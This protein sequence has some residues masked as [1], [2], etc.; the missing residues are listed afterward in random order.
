MNRYEFRLPDIGEGTAEAECVAWHVAPGDRVEED[1]PLVDVMTD[2]ATVEVTSPVAGIIRE[3][4]GAAGDMMAVGSTI[5]VFDLDAEGDPAP[6]E[7]DNLQLE[8]SSCVATPAPLPASHTVRVLA[9]PAL[10]ERAKTL[11][12][13]LTEV[14]GSGPHGR[15]RQSDL[16]AFLA[17]TARSEPPAR[18]AG[19]PPRSSAGV[20]EDEEG[21]DSVPVIGLRRRIAERM[22]DTKRRIPHFSYIEEVDVT[23]LMTL[24][25]RL[26][27]A[28]D[29]SR[30]KLSLLPFLIRALGRVLP[31]FPQI[32][33][34]YDDEAGVVHRHHAVHV[35]IATQTPAGL[36]V[37][38]IRDANKRDL[39]GNA[40]EL[41]RLAAAAR[42]GKS[43]T[44][45]LTGST[46]TITSLGAMGGVATTPVINSP[47]VAIIGVN[48]VLER[49]IVRDGRIEVAKM[50]NLSSSFDHRM[51][52]GW[53]AAAFIQ[54]VK[55]L[56][57]TPSL[58][59]VE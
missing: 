2:K 7:S 57:E 4:L 23:Q 59:F 28:S 38:V 11:G 43:P 45:D 20:V 41:G 21:I 44:A 35:G 16:E 55:S 14:D 47:E 36:V 22:Q 30:P 27:E 58:L 56:L 40:I 15:I 54:R 3:R 19:L 42:A 51:V 39:W 32:N 52:D 5:L 10:R 29:I 1:Q 24:R 12:V 26:N 48:K 33:A 9:S 25:S 13:D 46:I 34:R 17:Q 6:E 31:E 8:P 53:D 37:T 49:P 50:M 18:P